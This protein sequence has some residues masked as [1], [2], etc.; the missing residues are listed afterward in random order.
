M[1]FCFVTFRV[2][3]VYA[4]NQVE[5]CTKFQCNKVGYTEIQASQTKL[6]QTLVN[7]QARQET[8]KNS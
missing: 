2:L 1:A 3:A 6:D 5:W 7:F 4:T 8:S